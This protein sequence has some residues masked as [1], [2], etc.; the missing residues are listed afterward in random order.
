MAKDKGG[1][2]QAAKM[3]QKALKQQIK[4]KLKQGTD[5][6]A[7]TQVECEQLASTFISNLGL[8]KATSTRHHF[9]HHGIVLTRPY[10]GK[11]CKN[12]PALEGHL[13]KCALKQQKRVR[14][15]R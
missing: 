1:N 5:F 10:K 2:K 11:P 4:D 14:L 13:C 12:C 3:L 8:A 15:P 7:L 9:P 6:T